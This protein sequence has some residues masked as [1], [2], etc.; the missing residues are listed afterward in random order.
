MYR[1]ALL[2]LLLPGFTHAGV[3]VN[4]VAWMG[5]D[6]GGANCEWIELYNSGS[7]TVSLSGWTLSIEN[8]SGAI[9][10]L[11]L[12]DPDNV[13]YSGIAAGGYYLIARNSG[14]C[15]T[16]VPGPSADWLGSFGNGVSNSGA[17]LTLADANGTVDVVDALD[18]WAS[19]VGGD[20]ATPKKTPQLV[21]GAWYTGV[22]TPRGPN[23]TP[24]DDEIDPPEEND[25]PPVV[26]IGGTA[27]LVPV[28][29]PVPELYIEAGPNRVVTAGAHTPYTALVYD[30]TGKLRADAEVTWSFGD[31]GFV[32]GE[33]VSYAYR[34]PGTY[35]A[36]VRARA[37]G[38]SVVTTLEV[39]AD[40][41]A[42]AIAPVEGGVEIRNDSDRL[43]DLSSWR[44]RDG[45]EKFR[46]PEDFVVSPGRTAFLPKEVI[47]MEEIAEPEL[48]YPSGEVAVVATPEPSPELPEVQAVEPVEQR[49]VPAYAHTIAPAAPATLAAA[50]AAVPG[51]V[52]LKEDQPFSLTALIGSLVATLTAFVVP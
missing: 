35:E 21:S 5:T 15:S 50:G 30:S 31:G 19:S 43:A 52:V 28:A 29:R 36:V 39:V 8:A 18:G 10:T 14:S 37:K 41:P 26:T 48:L 17:K 27:P 4:E 23:S 51:N 46:L 22:P 11:A 44:I 47:D 7:E 42:L 3:V 6:L 33:R 45:R 13:V 24:P 32:R 1:A 34:T 38:T 16:I 40:T 2:V 49:T 25:T 9:T 20:N 12:D